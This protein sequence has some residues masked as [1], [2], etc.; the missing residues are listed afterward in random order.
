MPQ[1]RSGQ[2]RGVGMACLA[3]DGRVLANL[4]PMLQNKVGRSLLH[5]SDQSETNSTFASRDCIYLLTYALI[6]KSFS[7]L[8]VIPKI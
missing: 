6:M 4:S 8:E 7:S 2:Q 5:D 1:V 3:I